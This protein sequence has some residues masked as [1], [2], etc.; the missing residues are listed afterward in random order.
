MLKLRTLLKS[1]SN[2][3][4]RALFIFLILPTLLLSV[5]SSEKVKSL[6]IGK[7]MPVSDVEMKGTDGVIY[8]LDK[9]KAE[10]GL[11]VIFSCNTCPFVVGSTSFPGWE[12]KYNDLHEK[13]EKAGLG[14]VLINSNEAKRENEDSMEEM[15]K[16]SAEKGYKMTYVQDTDSKVADAFGAKTTPHVFVFDGTDKLIYRGSIDNTWDNQRESDIN[17]LENALNALSS[18]NNIS[19][20]DTAPRGCSIKRK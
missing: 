7:K 16:R 2:Q 18:G 6:K 19:E 5:A 10:K 4:L 13:A 1:L 8:T 14:F 12:G 15:I 17:Y 20:K 3:P 11:V 9:L